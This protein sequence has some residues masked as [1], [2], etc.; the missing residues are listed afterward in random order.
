MTLFYLDWKGFTAWEKTGGLDYMTLSNRTIPDVYFHNKKIA[1]FAPWMVNGTEILYMNMSNSEWCDG[2]F[3]TK[4]I[5]LLLAQV[6]T[7][8]FLWCFLVIFKRFFI[9]G[10]K[11]LTSYS[12]PSIF[13]Y[14]QK[15]WGEKL[16]IKNML[17]LGSF[18]KIFSW[19]QGNPRTTWVWVN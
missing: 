3:H 18:C 2:Y 15:F 19:G 8:L 6:C 1:S 4:T 9:I 13:S 7:I 10:W 16:L 11:S 17:Y 14:L 12:I 5:R